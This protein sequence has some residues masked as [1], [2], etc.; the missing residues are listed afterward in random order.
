MISAEEAVSRILDQVSI[1]PAEDTPI[2]ETLGQVVAEDVIAAFDIPPLA[3]SAMD[4]YAVRAEDTAGASEESPRWLRVV[5]EV[6]AGMLSARLV[7]PGTAIRI[8]T[9]A[10]VPEGANAVVQFENTSEGKQ[11]AGPP[12]ESDRRVAVLHPISVGGNVR[13]AG[14]DVRQ[15]SVV[16]ARGTVIRPAEIGVMASLG[17]TSARVHRRPR[18]AILSTGDEVVEPGQALGPG[19]IYDANSF[20]LAAQV[21]QAGGIPMRIGIA[22]DSRADLEA[23]LSRL[24]DADL[25]LTSAGVSVGDF[26]IVKEVLAAEGEVNFWRVRVKPGKPL[27]FGRIRGIPHLGLPGNPVSSMVAFELFA[28]PA[29]LKMLGRRALHKP[30]VEAIL[31]GQADNRDGRR[32]FL[33]ARVEKV[34]G[35]YV[36]RLTGPQGSGILTSMALANAL[37]I[38][39]ED[40]RRVRT[41]DRLQAMMLDWPEQE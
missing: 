31:E 36:A 4:G 13:Q 7:E 11:P 25:L 17:L 2:L 5:G 28:R 34:N 20:S 6:A 30:M 37:V 14:E 18:V 41:G 35:E 1:L 16:L 3:N 24:A 12:T 29:I 40:V 26:D 27:A 9:G 33:R 21:K 38:I 19:Q 23:K 22:Q 39:P 8:M 15:G 32:V 10:P